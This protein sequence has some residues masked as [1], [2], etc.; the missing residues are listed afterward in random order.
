MSEPRYFFGAST[1]EFTPAQILEQA[2]AARE[3]GFDGICCSD[4][5]APWWPEGQSA[6]AWVTLAAIGQAVPELPLGTAVTPILHHY[7]P[8]VVAQAFMSL[9]QLFP[10]RVFL[11]AGSGEALNEIPTGIGE[12]PAPADKIRRLDEGLE[13]IR[14]L[15]DGET[16]T[17]DASWFSLHDARLYTRAQQRPR[18][19][20][21]AFGPKAA[22]VAA[23]HGDGVWVDDA[24]ILRAYRDACDELGRD[25]GEAIFQTG[26]HFSRDADANLECTR[27][28]KPTSLGKA[29]FLHDLYDP[30]EMTRRAA[31]TISDEEHKESW[32]LSADAGAH[33]D[34]I[35]ELVDQ[36]ATIVNLQLIGDADPIGSIRRYGDEVLPRLRERHGA[37]RAA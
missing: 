15:W 13:A 3:A 4:H 10:G 1:E 18:L 28:W 21:S 33:V 6:Q 2:V 14:R 37:V 9:A 22:R 27:K 32:M 30:A 31:A 35:A 5:F 20:V 36:G 12:W 25:P 19:Y 24:K 26:F 7:H 16:V 29:V 8:A 11:G 23:K 34:S 17:M